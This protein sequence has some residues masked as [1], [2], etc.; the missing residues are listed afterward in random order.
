LP[1]TQTVLPR[2]LP[3]VSWDSRVGRFTFGED[4]PAWLAARKRYD[5]LVLAPEPIVKFPRRGWRDRLRRLDRGLHMA[6]DVF[7]GRGRA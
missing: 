5:Q 7:L 4:N 2:H 6:L 1:R 3:A